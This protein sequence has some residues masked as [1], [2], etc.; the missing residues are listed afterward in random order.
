MEESCVDEMNNIW[1]A[2]IDDV[3]TKLHNLRMGLN[4]RSRMVKTDRTAKK[5][6]F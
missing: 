2:S 5:K 3:P 6:Y 4:R 1:F